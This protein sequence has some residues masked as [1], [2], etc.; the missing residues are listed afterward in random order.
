MRAGAARD[1]TSSTEEQNNV[2]TETN[3]I[4]KLGDIHPSMAGGVEQG[5][6]RRLGKGGDRDKGGRERRGRLRGRHGGG[7]GGLEPP[8]KREGA[9]NGGRSPTVTLMI[10]NFFVIRSL[11]SH[12]G[13]HMTFPS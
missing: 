13:D 9:N 3:I 7:Q 12:C 10:R 6:K 5:S 4:E 1:Y 2:A 8:P 11:A